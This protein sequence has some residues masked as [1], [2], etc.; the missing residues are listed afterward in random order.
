MS[1]NQ[2]LWAESNAH[3]VRLI[4]DEIAEQGPMRFD[5]FME[6]ALYHPEYGY[7]HSHVPGPGRRGDFLT[8]PEAHPIF[9][10]TLATQIVEFDLLLE[11]P[12][13]FVLVEFG[14]GSGRLIRP[15]LAELRQ[16]HQALYQ[17][18]KYFPIETNRTRLSELREHLQGG[19]HDERLVDTPCAGLTGCILANEFLDALPVRRLS[20]HHSQLA[21]AYVAWNGNRIGEF[22]YAILQDPKDFALIRLDP[23][24][25][26]NPQMC[27]FGGP[28]GVIPLRTFS[29][30]TYAGLTASITHWRRG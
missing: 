13:P 10:A 24:V 30:V 4:R 22:A 23:G 7:Y 6:L 19:D 1:E 16:S 25:A 14:A 18:L 2:R 9:G 3:L 8:A 17:R 12:E 21:E 15:L 11:H 28:T 29:R 26:A 27:H 20:R 5:R